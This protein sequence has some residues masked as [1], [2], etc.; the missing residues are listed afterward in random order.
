MLIYVFFVQKHKCSSIL[1]LV[2]FWDFHY[3]AYHDDCAASDKV[4]PIEND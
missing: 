2:S 4:P 1:V 3:L